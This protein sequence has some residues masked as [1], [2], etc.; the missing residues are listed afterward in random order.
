MSRGELIGKYF[1]VL[2]FGFISL[3]DV[4]GNDRCI[5]EAARVSYAKNKSTKTDEENRKLIRYLMKCGHHSPF[6]MAELKFHI[7]IPIFTDRQFVRSR[8]F[9]RNE[10]SGRY[11]VLPTIFYTPSRKR[12]KKQ[13]TTNKQGSSNEE[14]YSEEEYNTWKRSIQNIR[15][16][17]VDGYHYDLS[18]GLT[19]ELARID[20]PLSTYTY[21][22]TKV[23]L[24]NLL[25]FLSLRLDSHAQ[26]EIQ[27]Y[28][29]IIAGIVKELFPYTWE[30][31]V[32]YRLRS[33]NFSKQE[34]II[35]GKYIQ[36][37]ISRNE[38]IELGRRNLNMTEREVEEFMSKLDGNYD[39]PTIDNVELDINTAKDYSYYEQLIQGATDSEKS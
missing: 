23:D 13:S 29:K 25:H 26:W 34:M 11:S 9:S 3:L 16:S 14:C 37:N 8:T 20:L 7:G 10:V 33:V 5:A 21:Y 24:R 35:L 30:A 17:I 19:K 32:D 38:M 4:M 36:H 1:G 39:L 6:E 18:T 2:D 28:A 22:Y 12:C 31:F 15:Q 27:Q